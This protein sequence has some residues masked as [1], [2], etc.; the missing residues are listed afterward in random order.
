[1]RR[2][3]HKKAVFI[4]ILFLVVCPCGAHI[5]TDASLIDFMERVLEGFE[6]WKR[7]K[8][9][10]QHMLNFHITAIHTAQMLYGDTELK[11]CHIYK[12][13]TYGGF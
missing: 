6:H 12:M 9:D 3:A 2:G 5:G 4:I 10:M 11:P 7:D 1:M 13:L 8:K